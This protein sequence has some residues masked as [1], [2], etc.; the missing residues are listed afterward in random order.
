MFKKQAI[1][2]EGIG[3]ETRFKRDKVSAEKNGRNCQT[4][5]LARGVKIVEHQRVFDGWK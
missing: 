4:R 3:G 1:V 2:L 5:V